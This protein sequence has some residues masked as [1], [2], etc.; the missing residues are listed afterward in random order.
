MPP[1]KGCG[2]KA[3]TLPGSGDLRGSALHLRMVRVV[4][5]VSTEIFD[6]LLGADDGVGP[7]DLPNKRGGHWVL[8]VSRRCSA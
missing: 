3:G 4:M 5:V 7:A 1:I 6:L 2:R 8:L